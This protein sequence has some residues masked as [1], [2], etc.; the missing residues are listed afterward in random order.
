MPQ[1]LS[2]ITSAFLP[3]MAAAIIGYGLIKRA[4]VYDYFIE[5]VF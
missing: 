1:I 2:Y 5:K 3:V 4:P